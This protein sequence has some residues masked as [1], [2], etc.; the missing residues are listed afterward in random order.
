MFNRSIIADSQTAI[1]GG[2]AFDSRKMSVHFENGVLIHNEDIAKQIK[3][4][5]EQTMEVSHLL[6]IKDMRQRRI[7]EK[8]LGKILN[9]FSP[10]YL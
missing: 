8:I 3:D 4:D 2:G 5:I 10:L 1:I 6:T 9:W 7:R